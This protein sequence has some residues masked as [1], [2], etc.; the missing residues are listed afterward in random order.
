[1]AFTDMAAIR[2]LEEEAAREAAELESDVAFAE[3]GFPRPAVKSQ[4]PLPLTGAPLVLVPGS[5]APEPM[6]GT[7][8]RNWWRDLGR[9]TAVGGRERIALDA[10]LDRVWTKPDDPRQGDSMGCG[11]AGLTN[12]AATA[13]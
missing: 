12:C 4:A 10:L 3:R 6:P 2:F 9:R 13:A 5:E 8:D 7:R 1:M 11:L